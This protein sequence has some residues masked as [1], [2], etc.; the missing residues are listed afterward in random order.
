MQLSQIPCSCGLPWRNSPEVA[1]ST[2]IK[3]RGRGWLFNPLDIR[4]RQ[5]YFDFLIQPGH[6]FRYDSEKKCNEEL[7]YEKA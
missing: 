3:C 6:G 4:N 1:P 5:S 2:C 7:D